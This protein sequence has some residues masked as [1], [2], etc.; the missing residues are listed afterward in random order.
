MQTRAAL[1]G[2]RLRF[3]RAGRKG[4]TRVVVELGR[5]GV[6]GGM[7]ALQAPAESQAPTGRLQ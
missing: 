1:I 6:D 5:G 3:E 2:A 4:G 7:A